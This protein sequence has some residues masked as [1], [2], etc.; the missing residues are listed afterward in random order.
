MAADVTA[1][2]LAASFSHGGKGNYER[3]G[4]VMPIVFVLDSKAFGMGLLSGR[5]GHPPTLFG[6]LVAMASLVQPVDFVV[7]VTEAWMKSVVKEVTSLDQ[8]EGMFPRG[9]LERLHNEG[10]TEVYTC[11]VTHVI[12]IRASVEHAKPWG[13]TSLWIDRNHSKAGPKGRDVQWEQMDNLDGEQYGFLP[14]NMLEAALTGQEHRFR[15]I[16]DGFDE[17]FLGSEEALRRWIKVMA[18]AG[19]I[20]AAMV[21]RDARIV[22]WNQEDLN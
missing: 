18:S 17:S 1:A 15:A 16:D 19:M 13:T 7:T 20:A 12:D 6:P 3:Y 11:V 22:E 10:D 5:D 8:A 21:I 2:E 14:S 9:T 4:E